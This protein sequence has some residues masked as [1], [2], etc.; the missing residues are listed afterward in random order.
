[1]HCRSFVAGEK[2]TDKRRQQRGQHNEPE[3]LE[4]KVISSGLHPCQSYHSE[5]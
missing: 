3:L 2:V 5:K 1:M 4:K